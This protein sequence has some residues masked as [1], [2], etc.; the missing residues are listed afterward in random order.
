MLLRPK[1]T[2]VGNESVVPYCMFIVNLKSYFMYAY[3]S[4][5]DV[6]LGNDSIDKRMKSIS[7]GFL[8]KL[9]DRTT[10]SEENRRHRTYLT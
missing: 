1:A 6:S 8:G 9:Y 5:W 4:T 3:I 7:K 2:F 10:V